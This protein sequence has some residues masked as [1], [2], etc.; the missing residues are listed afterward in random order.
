MEI[1][2]LTGGIA[3]GKT[4]V[5]RVFE[6]NGVRV[7]DADHVARLVVEPGGE[8]YDQVIEFF[9]SECL[10]P[11]GTLNRKFVAD[12][13]F[14]RGP[15]SAEMKVKYEAFIHEAIRTRSTKILSEFESEG[16]ELACYDAALLIEKGMQ[17]A[18]RPLVVVTCEPATQLARLMARNNLTER[19]ARYRINS[20]IPMA[21]KVKVADLVI[22]NDRKKADLEAEAERVLREVRHRLGFIRHSFRSDPC[23]VCGE[24]ECTLFRIAEFVQH[25]VDNTPR[26]S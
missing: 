23:E 20:Q 10:N 12:L 9:G 17:D 6:A 13:I 3:C 14:A 4:A 7:L 8:A 1:F 5:A 19:E 21:E 16:V 18:F 25:T 24:P 22:R 26:D 2:G 15:Y 11:D